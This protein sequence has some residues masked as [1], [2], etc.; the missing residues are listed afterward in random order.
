MATGGNCLGS[1]KEQIHCVMN[2]YENNYEK[3]KDFKG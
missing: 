3:V 1:H 2:K